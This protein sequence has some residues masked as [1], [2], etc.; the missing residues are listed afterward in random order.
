MHIMILKI[1]S[2]GNDVDLHVVHPL[3]KSNRFLYTSFYLM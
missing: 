3:Q 1:L 2:F